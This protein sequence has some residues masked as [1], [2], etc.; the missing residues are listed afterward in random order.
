MA[1]DIDPLQVGDV[2]LDEREAFIEKEKGQTQGRDHPGRKVLV[3][4]DGPYGGLKMYLGRF[5][6]VLMVAGGSGITFV[7]GA[8]E[9]T[10]RTKRQG[11][12]PERVDVVWVVRDMSKLS[13]LPRGGTDN[14][15]ATIGAMAPAL[16]YLHT[17][18]TDLKMSL[19]YSL[20]LTNPPNALPSV[21]TSLPSSTTISP[22]RPEISQIVREALPSSAGGADPEV[23]N[24]G[25]GGMAVIACGPEG[26]V[27]EAKN[28]VAGL[29]VGERVRV[30]GVEFHGECYAL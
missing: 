17:L 1:R 15:L 26:I 9:E 29:G 24:G 13:S 7:L 19:T 28:A 25:R 18:A 22:Y 14:I 3:M 11:N 8:I 6:G 5:E 16:A 2:D 23:A 20:Y 21:P 4:I 30:G 10:L 27:L 12:G